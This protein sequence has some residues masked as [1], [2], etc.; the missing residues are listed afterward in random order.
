M[1]YFS[2]LI[3]LLILAMSNRLTPLVFYSHGTQKTI[4]SWKIKNHF[5]RIAGLSLG[6][7]VAID[8]GFEVLHLNNLYIGPY[9]AIGKNFK[10][11]NFSE[12]EIGKFCM[13]AGEVQISNGSH[14]IESF[15][16]Y[17][18]KTVIGNGVWIGHGAQ[19]VG[20]N[21]SIGDNAVIGAGALVISDVLANEVVVGRP[22]KVV[23]VREPDQA[24]WHFGSIYFS[25][26]TFN[27]VAKPEK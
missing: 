27:I 22:Q 9:T 11:Y 10:V 25:P 20:T 5:L 15:L 4:G 7:N 16:P 8:S 6:K 13:I 26:S 2:Y 3:K 14:K 21:I 1:S 18:G 24:I 17:S 19:I 12:V 23:K